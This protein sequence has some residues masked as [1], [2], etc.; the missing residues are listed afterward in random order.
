[1][2]DAPERESRTVRRPPL[3]HPSGA[4]TRTPLL[5]VLSFLGTACVSS[6]GAMQDEGPDA[7]YRS[8]WVVERGLYV[9]A[10]R[11]T[12]E[13]R[14]DF[15]GDT[16]LLGPD[17]TVVPDAG[18]GEGNEVALGMVS[19]GFGFELAYAHIDYDDVDYRSVSLNG[20]YY[21]R[22]NE[23][24]QPYFLFGIFF[25]WAT[26]E[27]SS[28]SGMVVGDGELT[29]GFGLTLGAGVAWFLAD[30]VAFDLRAQGSLQEFTR[31]EG[32]LGFEGEIDD[33]VL[34]TSFG[35]SAGLTFYLPLRTAR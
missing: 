13:L 17:E 23:R 31:A 22:P 2:T 19:R 35:A 32:V 16:V 29:S 15:D 3:D 28:T 10:R 5:S 20:L 18:T 8:D 9:S 24:I 21:L 34:G 7:R 6:G 33:P 4:M 30:G 26:L 11:H 14:G 1:M 27:D 12:S 25:P